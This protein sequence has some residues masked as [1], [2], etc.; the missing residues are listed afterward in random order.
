MK[1][2]SLIAALA[3]GAFL[4]VGRAEEATPPATGGGAK[5]VRL[6][7]EMRQKLTECRQQVSSDSQYQA[8]LKAARQAQE[9]ADDYFLAKLQQVVAGDEKL[10]RYVADTIKQQKSSRGASEPAANVQ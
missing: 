1:R 6:T 10:A 8:L 9:R 2:I 3:I 7:A 4:S 5:Q